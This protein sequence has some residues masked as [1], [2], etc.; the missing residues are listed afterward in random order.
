MAISLIIS[1]TVLIFIF[2]GFGMLCQSYFRNKKQADQEW[3]AHVPEK[4]SNFGSIESLTILP[5][6]DWYAVK[7][8]L[9]GECGVSWLIQADRNNILLDTGVNMKKQDPSPLLQ[10]MKTLNIDLKDVQHL[11][12]SHPHMDHV[13][14]LASQK[15]RTVKLSTDDKDLSRITLYT[16]TPMTHPSA[17]IVLIHKPTVL[18]PGVASEGPISRSLFGMGMT[19]EQALVVNVT[20][21]GLVLIAGCGHQGVEKIFKRAEA[22]FDE[23]IFGFVGGLHYPVTASRMKMMGL[24]VQKLLGT[25]KL[26]WQKISRD[27]VEESIAFLKSKNLGVISISA[28]DSCDWTLDRFREAFKGIYKELKVGLPITI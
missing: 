13:G 18:M 7:E 20:G 22:V 3:S 11:F 25:G 26:P 8:P 4:L 14:G 28:H 21:K 9:I 24:P 27:E 1:G 23:P 10:N 19:R 2:M 5:L 16:S 17:K 6:I 15:A 12:I